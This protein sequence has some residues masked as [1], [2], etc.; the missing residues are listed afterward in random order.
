M[1]FISLL[2]YD[3]MFEMFE[4]RALSCYNY[5]AKKL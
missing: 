4:I 5:K 2:Y 1:N 3:D